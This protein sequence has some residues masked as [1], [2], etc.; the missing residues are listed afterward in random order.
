LTGE[1]YGTARVL[2]QASGAGEDG[3][4]GAVLHVEGTGAVDRHVAGGAGEG[5]VNEGEVAEEIIERV[6]V[7]RA[8]SHG[9]VAGGRQSATHTQSQRAAGDGGV[10]GE[11]I[12]AGQSYRAAG[13]FGQSAAATQNRRNIAAGDIVGAAVQDARIAG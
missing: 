10:A 4:D 2:G 6:N 8:A 13:G 9:D 1:G 12:L 11:S 5:A 3:A 7:E